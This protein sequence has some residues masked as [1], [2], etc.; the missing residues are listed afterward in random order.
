MHSKS[1][2]IRTFFSFL[3]H[4]Q[5]DI[6][7]LPSFF[8]ALP[9]ARV[10]DGLRR[11]TEQKTGGYRQTLRH[12]VQPVTG[13]GSHPFGQFARRRSRNRGLLPVEKSRIS[14]VAQN[15]KIKEFF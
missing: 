2:N 10:S 4:S 3:I 9:A 6:F 15:D 5:L 12:T 13:T 11:R 1:A 8:V 14:T 7:S